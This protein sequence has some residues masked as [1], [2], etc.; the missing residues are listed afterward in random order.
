M[1]WWKERWRGAGGGREGAGSGSNEAES[2]VIHC[3]RP[4]LNSS[5]WYA[6]N[7]TSTTKYTWYSFLPMSLFEQ[8]RRAA[9][10][11]FTAMAILSL[12]SFGPYSPI[13]LWLP[14][15]FVL[16]LGILRDFAEDLRRSRGDKE[17]NSRPIL[18]HTGGGQFEEKQ[19]KHL[20]VGDIV[21]VT[22]GNYFPSDLL[23]LSS[24]TTDGVCYVETMNLDGETNLKVRQALESTW[25]VG[26]KKESV[27]ENFE[28]VLEYEGPNPSLYTFVGTLRLEDGQTFPV[29]PSQLLLR[30]SSL[31][32]TGSI[33]GAVVY[34]GHDTKVMQNSLP[35]PSKRSRVDHTLDKII[36]AMFAVLLLV[37]VLTAVLLAV[38]TKNAGTDPWYLQPTIRDSY[39]NPNKAAVAGIISF[40]NSL[41]LY[42]Y[43]IPI[44]LY[45]SLEIVRVIQARFIAADIHMYDPITNKAAKVKSAGL[46]E[47]LGQVDTIFSDKTG[48]LTCNQMDFFRV[49]IAGVAYGI[50]TTE[51][52][53]AAKQLGLA[54]GGDPSPRD[55]KDNLLQFSSDRKAELQGSINMM[56]D[57][58]NYGPD[59]NPYREKGF[60]FY[61]PRLLGGNWIHEPSSQNIQ[62]FM[63]ILALCHTAIPDGIPEDPASMRYRAE[64]PDEAALVVAAK[65]FGFYFY[66]RTPT[67]LHVRETV[68]PNSNPVDQVYQLLNVLE[69]SSARKRMSVIVRFPDGRLLLLSKGADSVMLQ[70]VDKNKSGF[71]KETNKH[72]KDFGEVGLRT[73][74]VAYRQLDEEEYRKWQAK[75]AEARATVGR[76]RDLRTEELADEIE[77]GLTVVGGTGVEDKLQDGVPEAIDRFARAGI[78]IWVLTGDKVETAINIGY[79]CSLLRHGMDNLLVSLEGPEAHALE[80][81]ATRDNLSRDEIAEEQK[82][83]VGRKLSE[84]LDLVLTHHEN[85]RESMS[86][87]KAVSFNESLQSALSHSLSRTSTLSRNLSKHSGRHS[88]T[89]SA[90]TQNGF[91][92]M[93]L[94]SNHKQTVGIG[95]LSDRIG[96][97]ADYPLRKPDQHSHAIEYALVIDGQ[98]L[99]FI[100]AEEELQER[101]LRVCINCASVLCCRVSP[102]QKAQVT[103]LVRKGLGQNRLCLAIGDG[104]NDV[105][106]IQAADVGVG[107]AG[108]EG[109]QA[110][111]AADYA[112]A[113][114]RFLER[115]LLV[116]GRW[117]YR[118]ISLMIL[119][120]FYK[121]CMLGFIAF[122][123][124]C[125]AFFSGNPFY[126]DW[127]ASCYNTIFTALPV[128]V[129]GVLDQDVSPAEALRY[130]ELYRSGQRGEMFNKRSI[131]GWLLNSLYSSL[132][133]FFFPLA[134]YSGL[135]AI[136]PGG[137]VSSI[138]DYGAGMFTV[139]VLVPN[140]QLYMAVQYFTWIHHLAICAS[141]AIWYLFIIVYGALPPLWATNAYKEFV[142]VLAPSASYWLLQAVVIVITLLPEYLFR[143]LKWALYPSDYQIVLECTKLERKQTSKQQHRV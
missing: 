59:N 54:L 98:S 66:K 89:P 57:N 93:P 91:Q 120:F 82:A 41:I 29:G 61:D 128:C 87:A 14:L 51:V 125:F 92:M 123:C 47:E 32:N 18:V 68:S 127:Y 72:L 133:I 64:S 134:V 130:P 81:R 8:Y 13:S 56:D 11:Y 48:T 84:A 108:V 141:I 80:E 55:P 16:A 102:R 22:D 67:M 139:L 142:E 31:Q 5:F 27:L 34:T 30:D 77:Q 63:Q 135:S 44:A 103:R 138:Q 76:E 90:G 24:S 1:K 2:R 101:F 114:F 86:S 95:D 52:E 62:F 78:K 21:K 69:F 75:Y 136:R 25:D 19:W 17:V 106:M 9:Y 36:W 113:Q 71:V 10:W 37:S 15:L 115:L 105:G 119:Y 73:L 65:Q 12:L 100:L 140:L 122:L 23:L 53:R 97:A 124:N 58:N 28:A 112:I 45:V 117:C 126:N 85:L 94:T 74:V 137:Q 3:N 6:S 104:A 60:N 83:F 79:A 42:G 110:A 4:D 116:H 131:F 40:L 33:L 7:R 107:I 20:R 43:F 35:P 49:S 121:V 143:S 70:R 26:G 111:M 132:V 46:N 118:R 88:R 38:R 50:G 129:I 99:A 96:D 109:A 39:Y